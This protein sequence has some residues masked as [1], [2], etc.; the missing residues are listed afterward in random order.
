MACPNLVDRHGHKY[1][2]RHP[3]LSVTCTCFK[4]PPRTPPPPPAERPPPPVETIDAVQEWD[5]VILASD[6]QIDALA[7]RVARAAH[8][9][10]NRVIQWLHLIEEGID[11]GD[12]VAMLKIVTQD[13]LYLQF[14][15]DSIRSLPTIVGFAVEQN[16][17][18]LEFATENFIQ[19]ILD[20]EN[21]EGPD[22]QIEY[23]ASILRSAVEQYG[24]A[25]RF[26]R[27][28]WIA[29][30]DDRGRHDLVDGILAAAIR[31]NP[32]AGEYV[33]HLR[34]ERSRRDEVNA[35]A[36]L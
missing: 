3:Q 27:P 13:G 29:L 21:D 17:L 10:R 22:A 30:F 33:E 11:P 26:V 9:Q 5:P 2:L 14:M 1:H 28:E 20:E 12:H 19:L 24:L 18:A 35:A 34:A 23:A 8:E 4:H 15:P 25:V 16:G 6:T 36:V 7:L 32:D 31:Q